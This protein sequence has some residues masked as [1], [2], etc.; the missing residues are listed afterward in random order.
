MSLIT[1]EKSTR[2]FTGEVT[3]SELDVTNVEEGCFCCGKELTFPFIHWMGR[4]NMSFCPKCAEHM[5]QGIY[6]DLYR[7]KTQRPKK[8]PLPE[9]LRK[10]YKPE[11]FRYQ[12]FKKG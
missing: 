9:Y 7:L 4:Q 8:A 5:F 3:N 6:L 10:R 11:T 1:K 12:K 2:P